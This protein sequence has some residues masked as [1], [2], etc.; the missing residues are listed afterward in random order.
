[1]PDT[2]LASILDAHRQ[3]WMQFGPAK[4]LYHDGEGTLN[5]DVAEAVLPAKDTELRIRARGQHAITIEAGS[6]I[7]RHLLRVVEAKL[8][9]LDMPLVFARLLHGALFASNAFTFLQ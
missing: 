8:N 9:R 3:C 1:M 7:L 4:V 6:G 5:N 2:T